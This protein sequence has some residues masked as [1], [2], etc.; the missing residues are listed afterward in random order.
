MVSVASH[1]KN[2][3]EMAHSSSSRETRDAQKPSSVSATLTFL[4]LLARHYLLVVILRP[5]LDVVDVPL[6]FKCFVE[7]CFRKEVRVA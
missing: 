4:T 3:P 2:G 6:D 7:S 1:E 5:I